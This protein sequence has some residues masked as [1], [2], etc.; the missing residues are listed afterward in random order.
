MPII[1]MDE[2]G[3]TGTDLFNPNQ[4]IFTSATLCLSEEEAKELKKQFFPT[5][6]APELK[7]QRLKERHEQNILKFLDALS[8]KPELVRVDIIHKRYML[9]RRLVEMMIA[10]VAKKNGVNLHEK[11]HHIALANVFYVI[12]LQVVE[13]KFFNN[14]LINLQKM[15]LKLD[16]D[17]YDQF[18]E[19]LLDT[20]HLSELESKIQLEEDRK[21]FRFLINHILSIHT[22]FGFDLIVE[23]RRTYHA[24]NTNPL[25]ISIAST[26]DQMSM[27]GE[28]LSKEFILIFDHT[29]KA[30][31]VDN[32]WQILVNPTLP[33]AKV[34]QSLQFPIRLTETQYAESKKWAGIQ[35]ADIIAGA[36][37]HWAKWHLMGMP[38]TNKDDKYASDL[39]AIMLKFR[40]RMVW[41]STNVTPQS[42][43]YTDDDPPLNTD[44]F[45]QIFQ[46]HNRDY[47][48]QAFQRLR[49]LG[50]IGFTYQIYPRNDD[51]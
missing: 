9:V 4:P 46:N 45:D 17:S 20:N 27:W 39:E 30:I 40:T 21:S 23:L 16:R 12:L 33:P 37:N 11:G 50:V 51:H 44:Y 22:T 15:M 36:A 2:S 13:E 47:Y 41:P 35:L 42:L 28:D 19:P 10:P 18:F 32:I 26:L 14:L 48:N 1:F 7:H 5:N 24:L 49:K 43:G 38:L 25:D 3:D 34:S 6:R 29:L 8:K 31:K